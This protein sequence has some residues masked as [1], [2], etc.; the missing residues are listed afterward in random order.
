MAPPSALC[1]RLFRSSL[2]SQQKLSTFSTPGTAFVPPP[3]VNFPASTKTLPR[4]RSSSTAEEPKTPKPLTCF[5][6]NCADAI[7]DR[8]RQKHC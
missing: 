1:D 8:K 2:T 7:P 5:L 6:P 3:A 4:S